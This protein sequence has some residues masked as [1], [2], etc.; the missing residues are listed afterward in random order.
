MVN[1]QVYGTPKRA[2]L[3]AET[4]A[5][6]CPIPE[7]RTLLHVIAQGDDH[8]EKV[9]F[10]IKNYDRNGP[11]GQFKTIGAT[12][13]NA[14]LSTWSQIFM[15][16]RTPIKVSMKKKRGKFLEKLASGRPLYTGCGWSVHVC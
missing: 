11:E 4:F 9:V 7:K 2:G 13:C 14:G 15:S 8:N 1:L 12:M 10:V 3:T 16:I 5:V 6:T